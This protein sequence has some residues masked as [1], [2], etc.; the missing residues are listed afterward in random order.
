MDIHADRR[1]GASESQ[2]RATLPLEEDGIRCRTRRIRSR[3]GGSWSAEEP[4][5][6]RGVNRPGVSVNVLRARLCG[7]CA[8]SS[9][10]STGAKQMS[11]PS[12]SSL[13]V[14]RDSSERRRRLLAARG[15]LLWSHWASK[16]QAPKLKARQQFGIELRLDRTYRNPLAVGGFV[17][18]VEGAPP[19]TT[20]AS[21][22]AR[23]EP[24]P[25]IPK[26]I[27]PRVAAPSTIAAST[28]WP[29]PDLFASKSAASIPTVSNMPPPP[30]SATRLS[31]GEGGRSAEP[32]GQSMPERAK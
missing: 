18:A 9:G 28:T 15:H 3:A 6:R 32:I 2:G 5:R 17:D 21:R 14:S 19:S 23:Q 26:I 31:G 11:V 1:N 24:D 7:C 27:A 29:R 16:P 13:H 30:K 25:I 22:S 8:T 10:L 4:R 20:L 12:S